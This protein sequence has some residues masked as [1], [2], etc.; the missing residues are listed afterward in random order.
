MTHD[1]TELAS[2]IRP[3]DGDVV[4]TQ[5][6]NFEAQALRVDMDRVWMQHVEEKLPRIWRT[7]ASSTRAAVWFLVQPGAAIAY[8]GA[9]VQAEQVGIC[10]I[11]HHIWQRLTGPSIWG[12]LSLSLDEWANVVFPAAECDPFSSDFGIIF[13]PRPADLARLQRLHR[14]TAQLA[15]DAPELLHHSDVAHGIEESLIQAIVE[16]LQV[17]D[18]HIRD[19]PAHHHSRI[20]RQFRDAIQ[21]SSDIPLYMPELCRMMGISD[22]TLRAV[23]HKYLGIG[24]KKYLHL[25]RM[26]LARRAL[27]AAAPTR[28]IVTD[29]ATQFGFWELGRF[30]VEYRAL[31]GESP[32]STLRHEA[33]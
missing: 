3:V 27:L 25:R 13:T 18:K 24:P 14:A 28:T 1:P 21:E 32:S 23:C 12:S 4:V 6:G 33:A 17:G 8:Q 15:R 7:A 9:E 10:P 26:H 20:M 2:V 16:C 29:V 30:A 11:G 5:S 31:F 19:V 22:R